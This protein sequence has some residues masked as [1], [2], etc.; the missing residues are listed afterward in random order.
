MVDRQIWKNWKDTRKP[1]YIFSSFRFLC[2]SHA[3]YDTYYLLCY[4]SD[5]ESSRIRKVVR[6]EYSQVGQ[7]DEQG[8]TGGA[9][10]YVRV[11]NP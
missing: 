6:E 1:V 2:A 9:I 8:Y 10:F 11:S 3:S 7:M 4:R 5:A